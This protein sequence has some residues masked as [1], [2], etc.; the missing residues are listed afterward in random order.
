MLANGLRSY[1]NY[2]QLREN[3]EKA[4]ASKNIAVKALRQCGSSTSA[5]EY[6]R[7]LKTKSQSVPL[8]VKVGRGVRCSSVK[9]RLSWGHE[10]SRKG[11]KFTREGDIRE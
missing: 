4:E 9:I 3:L 1:P 6:Y 5:A 2:T 8:E 7:E 11:E 10:V